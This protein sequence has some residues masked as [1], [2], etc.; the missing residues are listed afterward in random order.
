MKEIKVYQGKDG[1]QPFTDWLV[2]IK[3]LTARAKIRAF[4]DRVALGGSKKNVEPLGDGV[5]E[6][7][8]DYGP[9]YRIYFGEKRNQIIILLY[10]GTKRRQQKDIDL[11][12]EYWRAYS[13][14]T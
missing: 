9:G 4:I 3:D 10:G 13:A 12:K 1:G 5:F 7:K 6:L 2:S 8:L 11:A 14:K